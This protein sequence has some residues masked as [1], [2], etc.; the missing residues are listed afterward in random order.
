MCRTKSGIAVLAN[1]ELKVY[2][3]PGEDSHE[4]IRQ[5]YNI[6][7]GLGAGATR[8]TPVE[9]IPVRGVEK[10]A[11]FDF[12]FDD[13]QPAWWAEAFT[14][15]AKR[16]LWRAFRAEWDG[17]TLKRGGNLYLRSLTSLPEGV[18]LEAGG[19]LDLSSLTSLPEGVT[20]KAKSVWNGKTWLSVAEYR[21]A[22]K[23]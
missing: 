3:L 22:M 14:R 13:G 17:K 16:E 4:K 21:K 6:Q 7:D 15:Q 20:L 23:K 1:D 8:Q 2:H 19:D 12:T 18:T 11:D 5:H 10:L 9:C